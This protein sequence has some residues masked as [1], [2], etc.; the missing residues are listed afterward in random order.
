VQWLRKGLARLPNEA[1]LLVRLAE[2]Y[3][4]QGRVSHAI[5]AATRAR[6]GASADQAE[7]LDLLGRAYLARGGHRRAM[8]L[9]T[10]LLSEHPDD[11]RGLALRGRASLAAGNHAAAARDLRRY[12]RLRPGNPAGYRDLAR[13]LAALGESDA[14]RVQERIAAYVARSP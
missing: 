7:T 1:R 3:L 11:P 12:V 13:C 14:A 8:D 9:A 5:E 10:T 2:A 4:L 6:R